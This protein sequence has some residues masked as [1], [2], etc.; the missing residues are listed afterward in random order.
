MHEMASFAGKAAPYATGLKLPE[1]AMVLPQSLQLSVFNSAALEAQQNCVRA[2]Y[3]YARAS[4]Y[5]VGEYQTQLL[6]NPKLIL[7]PSPWTLHEQAW[8]AILAKVR[9][10]APH[11]WSAGLSMTMSIFI[12]PRVQANW[13]S[14]SILA[15]SPRARTSSPG[16]EEQRC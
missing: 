15:C 16:R 9:A 8:Q 11:C 3:H 1:V 6:G 4:A 2:L 13:D 12:P 14:I 7:L 10:A 5:A